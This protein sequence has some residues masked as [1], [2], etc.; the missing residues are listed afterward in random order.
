MLSK[1]FVANS[2]RPDVIQMYSMYKKRILRNGQE[3]NAERMR[4]A[5]RDYNALSREHKARISDTEA[6]VPAT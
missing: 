5:I 1:M 6:K 3:P 2:F 4:N